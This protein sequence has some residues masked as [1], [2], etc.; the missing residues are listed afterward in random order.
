MKARALVAVKRVLDYNVRVRVKSD[1]TG[2]DL[3]GVKMSMNPFC[4]NAVEESVQMK[5]KGWVSEVIAVTCGGKQ[6][7]AVLRTALAMGV[8]RAIHVVEQEPLLPLDVARILRN[9]A[10]KEDVDLVLLGKQAVDDDCNQTGQI[11][12][13]LLGWSQC[14]FASK[15]QFN[16]E[17]GEVTVEREVDSG[18]QIVKTMLPTVVTSD[19]RLNTPRYP[20]LTKVLKAKKASVEHMSLEELGVLKI[21]ATNEILTDYTPERTKG[22]MVTTTSELVDALFGEAKALQQ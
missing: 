16:Q 15:I 6:D 2:V 20:A 22:K 8:D 9:V 7:E 21:N 11:L 3:S 5:E 1:K 19:L 17:N 4:E 12:A 18:L 13:G 10:R 14:S